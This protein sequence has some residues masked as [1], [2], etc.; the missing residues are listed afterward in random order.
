MENQGNQDF[1]QLKARSIKT[2][3]KDGALA[4]EL[5]VDTFVIMP[6][7]VYLYSDYNTVIIKEGVAIEKDF[8]FWQCTSY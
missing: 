1:E 5:P 8:K 7:D 2:T 6:K 4:I 3:I